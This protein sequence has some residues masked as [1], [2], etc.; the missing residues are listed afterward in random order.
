VFAHIIHVCRLHIPPDFQSS[1]F[2]FRT[3]PTCCRGKNCAHL[4]N[5][6]SLAVYK[7]VHS[8]ILQLINSTQKSKKTNSTLTSSRTHEVASSSTSNAIMVYSVIIPTIL[9][10]STALAAPAP[11]PT[12]SVTTPKHVSHSELVINT[13]NRGV[14]CFWC[15]D[16]YSRCINVRTKPPYLGM[17]SIDS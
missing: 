16:W 7:G 12:S 4:L 6:T 10:A 15:V 17:Y 11:L 1:M 5:A 13:E 9:L 8:P 2:P 3:Q 14:P